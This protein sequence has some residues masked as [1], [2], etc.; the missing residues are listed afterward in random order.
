MKVGFVQFSPVF[1]A[2]EK[3]FDKVSGLVKNVNADLL[4]LPELFNTGY[5]FLNKTELQ[6]LAEKVDEGP[7]YEF[8]RAL[9]QKKNWALIYGFAEKDG[10]ALYNSAV[11]MGPDGLIGHYRKTHLFFEESFIFDP[12]NLP[13]QVFEYQGVKFGLLICFDYIYPEAMRTVALKGAQ[14]VALPANLVLPYCPD[15]LVTRSLENR[16]YTILADRTGTEERETKRLSFIGKS[17]IVAP[18]G[19]ILLRVNDE[20]CV[21]VIDIDPNLALDKR[22]TPYNDIFKQRRTDLYFRF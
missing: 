17:E 7:T 2:K 12:G 5:L 8:A 1:G 9:C 16:I 14:V 10:N 3:N 22:V 21:Q 11:L 6:T 18:D 20:E 4:V 13:Y 15:A 19:T